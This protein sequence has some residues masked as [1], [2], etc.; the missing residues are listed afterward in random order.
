MTVVVTFAC[1]IESFLVFVAAEVFEL[2]IETLAL[3]F[4][5]RAYVE[6]SWELVWSFVT[7]K[8]HGREVLLS[9]SHRTDSMN[10]ILGQ[11]ARS[12][13]DTH[14]ATNQ[15]YYTFRWDADRG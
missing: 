4:M 12:A 15:R 3:F 2:L 7:V 5:R 10:L 11:Y 6:A 1:I 9:Y 13:R 8:V 14:L